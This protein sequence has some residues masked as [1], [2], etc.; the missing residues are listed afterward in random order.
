MACRFFCDQTGRSGL[1]NLGTNHVP[2]LQ[3]VKIGYIDDHMRGAP[4]GWRWAK[5]TLFSLGYAAIAPHLARACAVVCSR[6]AAEDQRLAADSESV[7]WWH[8]TA[9]EWRL[10]VPLDTN[11]IDRH[12]HV[13]ALLTPE[14]GSR[15]GL[16]LIDLFL[17]FS[18]AV[19]RKLHH[20]H[21]TSTANDGPEPQHT[22][23]PRHTS[24]RPRQIVR[25]T[26]LTPPSPLW[27]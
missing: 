27:P 8:I 13:T 23:Q 26:P 9:L 4:L 16:V 5:S 15:W 21:S 3:C 22:T 1:H 7:T 14:S 18:H 6:R 10:R 17:L 11:S 12:N 24:R 2:N 20:R 19:V 25:S